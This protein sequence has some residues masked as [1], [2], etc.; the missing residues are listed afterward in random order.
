MI[1]L[2]AAG[3][4]GM[5]GWQNSK[6]RDRRNAREDAADARTHELHTAKMADIAAAQKIRDEEQA[7]KDDLKARLSA[8]QQTPVMQGI[9][10]G[11]SSFDVKDPAAAV[12]MADMAA[13]KG[14][15][16]ALNDATRVSTGSVGATQNGTVAGK[17]VIA[18]P[19][20]AQAA[21]KSM[22]LTEFQKLQ[23][24]QQ[25]AE[26]FGKMDISDDV[27]GKL[28]T[29]EKEGA[30]RALA[31]AKNGDFEGAAKHYQATGADRMPEGARFDSAIVVDP[32]TKAPRTVIRMVGKDGVPIIPDVD[33]AL[34]SY[35]SPTEQ[36]NMNK[37]D[38]TALLEDRRL[39]AAEKRV[40]IA[41]KAQQAQERKIDAFI[42]GGGG[43]GG[44]GGG[45]SAT[46]PAGTVNMDAIDKTLTPLFAREDPATGAKSLDTNALM[47]VRTLA[48]RMPAAAAGDATGAAFQAHTMYTSALNSAG[49]DHAKAMQLIQ[50]AIN[51]PAAP[52]PMTG[53]ANPQG[54]ANPGRS[55]GQAAAPKERPTAKD[56]NVVAR[57]MQANSQAHFRQATGKL[58]AFNK[59]PAVQ[60]LRQDHS[61]ALRAGKP[62][63]ANN[64]MRQIDEM[65]QKHMAQQ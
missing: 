56:P 32:A 22:A 58:E 24:R 39:T 30:F 15:N 40:E 25:A 14:E 54:Q 35:L 5:A 7:Y 48:T 57:E 27:R 23:A 49:G 13:A 37:G 36:Y 51:P 16:V 33:M 34:R 11:G 12:M 38:K 4:Y 26:K 62:M 2:I 28:Q 59:D 43:R 20:Q 52:T 10:D 65:K 31:L 60:Q 47:T 9:G 41:E 61:R 50:Q 63:E 8:G 29:L 53:A 18:D 64:I 46:A 6:N 17:Q 42:S 44:S 3:L 55:V 45:S 1:P 21:A 19:A